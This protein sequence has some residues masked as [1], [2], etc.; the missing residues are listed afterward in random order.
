MLAWSSIVEKCKL[1]I[2]PTMAYLK[3]GPRKASHL[4]EGY[5]ISGL[6]VRLATIESRAQLASGDS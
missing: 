1:S 6:K 2:T 3:V 5:L 4:L